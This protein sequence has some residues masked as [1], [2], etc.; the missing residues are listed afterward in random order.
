MSDRIESSLLRNDTNILTTNQAIRFNR[1]L[2]QIDQA[3]QDYVVNTI[4]PYIWND[5]QVM[6]QVPFI[7][8][9]GQRWF[10]LRSQRFLTDNNGI[11]IYPILTFRRGRVAKRPVPGS[12]RVMFEGAGTYM[13]VH[14]QIKKRDTLQSLRKI[15]DGKPVYEVYNV[16]LPISV[17]IDYEFYLIVDNMQ[18]VNTII[19]LFSQHDRR[20][21]NKDLHL[22]A[23]IQDFSQTVQIQSEGQ[24]L[25]KLQFNMKVNASIIP[26]VPQAV[27][28]QNTINEFKINVSQV[29]II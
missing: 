9:S 21:W 24:R 28:K 20:L 29:E 3:I 15:N 7:Y 23:F 10:Q 13:T 6:V 11:P 26:D 5:E 27:V 1:S 22:I 4:R 25:V 18:H 2:T 17:E 8:A 12:Q 16:V 14:K 19:Q